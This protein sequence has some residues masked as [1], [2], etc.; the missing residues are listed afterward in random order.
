MKNNKSKILTILLLAIITLSIT[1]CGKTLEK[2]NDNA[3]KNILGIWHLNTNIRANNDNYTNLNSLFGTCLKDSD[4]S[5]TI[6]DDNTFKLNIGCYYNLSGKY[7]YE[8][9]TISFYDTTDTNIKN[10]DDIEKNLEIKLI[11]YKDKD[12]MQMYLYDFEDAKVYIFFE[13]TKDNSYGSSDVPIIEF[14]NDD[15]QIVNE[16]NKS[17]SVGDFKLSFGKYEMW[18]DNGTSRDLI[19]TIELKENGE[20]ELTL[21]KDNSKI[22]GT[23]KECDLESYGGSINHCLCLYQGD[24]KYANYNV[25]NDNELSNQTTVSKYIG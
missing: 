11:N 15:N 18:Q 10:T 20:F 23:Y 24:K 6:N 7:K 5:L 16:N 2:D 13:Q 21:T 17:I 8:N 12:L 19:S 3:S 4:N 22:S 1:G 9:N 14:D 25:N